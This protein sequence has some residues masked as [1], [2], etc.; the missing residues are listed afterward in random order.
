[1]KLTILFITA[2]ILFLAGCSSNPEAKV[3]IIKW[4]QKNHSVNGL[5]EDVDV[6]FTIKNAGDCDISDVKVI[7]VAETSEGNSFE[8]TVTIKSV[9]QGKSDVSQAHIFVDNEK[10]VGVEVSKIE[11]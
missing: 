11:Y 1:M 9:K 10:C 5:F 8:E 3:E 6:V 4:D 7:F 2:I